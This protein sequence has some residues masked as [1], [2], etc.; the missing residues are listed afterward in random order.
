ME[1]RLLDSLHQKLGHLESKIQAYRQDL[2]AD[3]QQYCNDLL[4]NVDAGVVS[5]VHRDLALSFANYPTLRPELQTTVQ[6]ADSRLSFDNPKSL[7]VAVVFQPSPPLA[8]STRSEAQESSRKRE[9]EELQGIFTPSYLPLLDCSPYLAPVASPGT[10]TATTSPT[11]SSFPLLPESELARIDSDPLMGHG[12]VMDELTELG[13][14]QTPPKSHVAGE[15]G[16]GVRT[17]TDDST[18]SV[19]SDKSD[20]KVRRS[21]LRRSSSLSKTP[22]S[23]RRVRFEFMGAEVLPTASPRSSEFLGPHI[24]SPFPEVDTVTSDSILGSDMEEPFLPPRKISSSDALRALSRTPMEEGTI[25]TLVNPGS[26]ESI[27]QHGT[28]NSVLQES[29]SPESPESTSYAQVRQEGQEGP[30]DDNPHSSAF[31]EIHEELYGENETD[32]SSDE[33]FLAMAKPKSRPLQN[34]TTLR[35]SI[36]DS[37]N[38]AAAAAAHN[39][40]SQHLTAHGTFDTKY[41]RETSDDDGADD[42]DDD[43]FHFEPGGLTAPPKP[44]QKPPHIQEDE[45]S[46]D[47]LPAAPED[48]SNPTQTIYATSPAISIAKTSRPGPATSTAGRFQ[49][50]SIGSYK[51]RPVVMPIVRDPAV[52]AR[53]ASLGQFETFVGSIDGRSGMDKGDLSSFRASVFQSAFTGTPRSFTERFLIEEAQEEQEKNKDGGR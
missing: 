49:P 40:T 52:H 4:R 50:G 28:E 45:E 30:V 48:D 37:F 11:T 38:I 36:S 22:Q 33:D 27:M 10:P 31:L 14:G 13:V 41:V 26:D 46:D 20:S 51:G 21:A 32:E 35:S 3:L 7:A 19:C 2:I 8:L 39:N 18:S 24:T 23:P 17:T 44:R 12:M 42:L 16:N 29:D 6:S 9:S 34:S 43:M 53:A 15:H 25:W 47:G 5:N 1:A